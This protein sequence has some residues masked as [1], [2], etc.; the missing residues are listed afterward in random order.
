V[1]YLTAVLAVARK[2]GLLDAVARHG[3]GAAAGKAAQHQQVAGE[4]QEA[5]CPPGGGS[6]REAGA[7]EV[8]LEAAPSRGAVLVAHPCQPGSIFSRSVVL[9][10][11][12]EAGQGSYGLILN[13][14][15]GSSLKDLHEKLRQLRGGLL[16]GSSGLRVV[17]VAAAAPSSGSSAGQQAGSW[18]GAA[19]AAAAGGAEPDWDSEEGG[20]E[21]DG[22]GDSADDIPAD[23]LQRLADER[24]AEAPQQY[25]AAHAALQAVLRHALAA[26]WQR[27]SETDESGN[28]IEPPYQSESEEEVEE[29]GE[30]EEDA[31]LTV[32][33][34]NDEEAG[35][36]SDDE[37]GLLAVQGE[38]AA[39]HLGSVSRERCGV[40]EPRAASWPCL[41][42]RQKKGPP[43]GKGLAPGL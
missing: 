10:C 7:G 16:G 21:S 5:G 19:L 27:R 17:P 24:D 18:H 23:L 41:C 43:L 4:Q 13:K 22:D 8:A 33:W 40:P 37:A 1:R 20:S 35:G 3:P 11:R 39:A 25:Y 32:S 6:S 36:G 9:L 30:D 42:G 29:D 12:H 26:E 31:G 28:W 15:L 34:G 38:A 14:P 2:H